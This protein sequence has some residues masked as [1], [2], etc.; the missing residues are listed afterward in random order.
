V[1]NGKRRCQ[2]QN[3]FSTEKRKRHLHESEWEK[4]ANRLY[5]EDP[6]RGLTSLSKRS[7]AS[8][9]RV[10]GKRGFRD[11]IRGGSKKKRE[12]T[13]GRGS[14]VKAQ[15]GTFS[16]KE[17]LMRQVFGGKKEELGRRR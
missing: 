12:K 5:S 15:E 2:K 16:A 11:G 17:K 8:N 13:V 1:E 4:A 7:S 10:R 9:E 3:I 6:L 14:L